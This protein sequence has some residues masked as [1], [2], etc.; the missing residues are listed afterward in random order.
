MCSFFISTHGQQLERLMKRDMIS[1]AAALQKMHAQ[2]PLSVKCRKA[3]IIIDNSKSQDVARS[4]AERLFE[5]MQLISAGR[6]NMRWIC[7]G[8][9]V[10]LVCVALWVLI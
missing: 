6:G 9:C 5:D 8:A 7:L 1:E 3:D 4:Q 10:L 2:L